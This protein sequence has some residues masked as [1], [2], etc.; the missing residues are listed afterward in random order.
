MSEEDKEYYK[1]LALDY[2]NGAKLKGYSAAAHL[3][4][5]DDILFW[6]KV[7][8]HFLPQ[9][10]FDYIT[11]T[12]TPKGTDA[13]GCETCLKYLKLGCLSKEFFICID[14]DYRWLLQEKEIDIE[15]FVFQ[16]YTYSWENHFCYFENIRDLGLSGIKTLLE[17]YSELLYK[18]FIYHI[19]SLKHDKSF[20]KREFKGLLNEVLAHGSATNL[21]ASHI[22]QSENFI[23]KQIK[24]FKKQY[25]EK[26]MQTIE[27]QCDKLGL[28]SKNGYLYFR[29][30]NVFEFILKITKGIYKQK[31]QMVIQNYTNEE[32]QAYFAPRKPTRK[33][34]ISWLT[35]TIYFDKYNEI[36]KIKLDA[37]FYKQL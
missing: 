20:S 8:Q 33:K 12:Q 18:P 17:K 21:N 37:E 1:Q 25:K 31:E 7:F 29:G 23:E 5:Q 15:H 34:Q 24:K 6:D 22:E 9:Y 32:K 26:D 28:N 11:Y 16:T 4:A 27:N 14:S 3:E 13:T 36:N 30:H 10:S 35:E 2:G 19:Y